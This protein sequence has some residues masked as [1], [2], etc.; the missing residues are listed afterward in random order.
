MHANHRY[1]RSPRR[2]ELEMLTPETTHL[3]HAGAVRAAVAVLILLALLLLPG[4][5]FAH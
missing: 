5:V 1:G 4:P 2:L 3:V